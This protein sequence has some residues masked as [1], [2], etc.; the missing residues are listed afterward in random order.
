MNYMPLWFAFYDLRGMLLESQQ[1]SRWNLDTNE[2]T[3]TTY[4]LFID[5]K[6]IFKAEN[7]IGGK[8]NDDHDFDDKILLTRAL[9]SK[10]KKTT[11]LYSSLHSNTANTARKKC[12]EQK[13]FQPT[14]KQKTNSFQTPICPIL[15]LTYPQINHK[16]QST[17]LNSSSSI[18][19]LR[20]IKKQVCE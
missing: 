20:N 5:L 10:E 3:T 17:P 16:F 9:L 14:N 7:V 13:S 11:S 12:Y 4:I 1:N 18:P 15:L 2:Y 8:D 19:L 6:Q